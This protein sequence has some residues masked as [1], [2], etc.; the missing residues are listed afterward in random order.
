MSSSSRRRAAAAM[1]RPRRDARRRSSVEDTAAT[2]LSSA[3]SRARRERN[4]KQDHGDAD[5]VEGM[6]LLAEKDDGEDRA[7]GGDE[8]RGEARLVRADQV[9]AAIPA[10]I[11]QDRGE[12][13]DIE[14]RSR[15]LPG[16]DHRT[17]EPGFGQ[18]GGREQ[19]GARRRDKKD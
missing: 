15:A 18:I 19:D 3:P 17:D 11:G 7:E 2:P 8:M 14:D 13:G 6:H 1:A 9:H 5:E 12:A 4:A 16:E 10:E